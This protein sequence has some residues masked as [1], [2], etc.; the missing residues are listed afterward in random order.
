MTAFSFRRDYRG[1]DATLA[2]P[3][4]VTTGAI[5]LGGPCVIGCRID[6]SF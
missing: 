4:T 5:L 1:R 6:A 2:I 3:Q